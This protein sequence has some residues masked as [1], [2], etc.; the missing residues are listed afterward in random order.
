MGPSKPRS[1]CGR[2]CGLGT[3][4]EAG[5]RAWV[6]FDPRPVSRIT[7]SADWEGVAPSFASGKEPQAAPASKGG[8][9]DGMDRYPGSGGDIGK[10]G[11]GDRH[12]RT[13]LA[14]PCSYEAEACGMGPSA[15]RS[16]DR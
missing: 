10:A 16:Y 15:S 6:L 7:V 11:A 4:Y 3:N 5:P 13:V 1:P 8:D 14:K 2:S 9:R 12:I